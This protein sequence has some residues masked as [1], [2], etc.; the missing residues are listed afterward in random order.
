MIDDA[1]NKEALTSFL[2]KLVNDSYEAELRRYSSL[3]ATSSRLLTCDSIILVALSSIA[4][5]IVDGR[6]NISREA[7][8]ACVCVAALIG[9]SILFSIICQW[10]IGYKDLASPG[11]QVKFVENSWEKLSSDWNIAK[12]YSKTLDIMYKSISS[13]NNKISILLKISVALL[14]AALAILLIL[15]LCMINRACA[16]A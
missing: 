8:I 9:A 5:L 14:G 11:E 6:V 7:F 2:Q 12:S 10:R 1:E 4:S 15:S 16:G 13:R 3:L